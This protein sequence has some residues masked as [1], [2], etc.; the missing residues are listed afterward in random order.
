METQEKLAAIKILCGEAMEYEDPMFIQDIDYTLAN[1]LLAIHDTNPQSYFVDIRGD[2][3]AW[4][5]VDAVPLRNEYVRWKLRND[6]LD[7]H[8]ENQPA[9]IDFLYELLKTNPA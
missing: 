8:A 5:N 2:F 6:S 9:T 7:W 4:K 1:V 3:W